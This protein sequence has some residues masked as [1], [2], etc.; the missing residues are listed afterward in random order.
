MADLTRTEVINLAL[1]KAVDRYK[2]KN[3]TINPIPKK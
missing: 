2:K 3:G 1:Q